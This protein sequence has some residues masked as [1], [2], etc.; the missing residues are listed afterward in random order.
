M[1]RCI[2]S[3]AIENDN[4]RGVVKINSIWELIEGLTIY[5][6]EVH[7]ESTSDDSDFQW[8][9]M[10]NEEFNKYFRSVESEV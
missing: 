7:L 1:Y 6:G 5:D 3:I 8:I 9:E 2:K 10:S 4:G